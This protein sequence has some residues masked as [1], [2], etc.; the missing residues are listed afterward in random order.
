MHFVVCEADFKVELEFSISGASLCFAPSGALIMG[1]RH[2]EEVDGGISVQVLVLGVALNDARCR[3]RRY[4]STL[5]LQTFVLGPAVGEELGC[6]GAGAQQDLFSFDLRAV[7]TFDTSAFSLVT[8]K[9]SRRLLLD[10]F[11]PGCKGSGRSG[12][13]WLQHHAVQDRARSFIPRDKL[14]VSVRSQVLRYRCIK[15]TA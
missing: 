8:E 6:P 15:L 10:L 4:H 1:M 9:Q 7:C 2:A 12:L 3:C 11:D 5:N 14:L 13:L